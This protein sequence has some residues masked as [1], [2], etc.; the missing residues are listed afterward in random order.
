MD[1]ETWC[2]RGLSALRLHDLEASVPSVLSIFDMKKRG[3]YMLVIVTQGTGG[4]ITPFIIRLERFI[5]DGR[6]C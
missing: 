6:L 3:F 2:H 4:M 1:T 5:H